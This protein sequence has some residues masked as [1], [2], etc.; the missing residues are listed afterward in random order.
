MSKM[1]WEKLTSI[2]ELEKIDEQ[3]VQAP[4]VIFKHS[5]KCSIS[6][7]ALDRI[8]RKWNQ[9]NHPAIRAY[10][11]DLISYKEVSN[12]IAAKYGVVHQSP[13]ILMIESGKCVYNDSHFGISYDVLLDKMEQ[14]T[15]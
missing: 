1:N 15:A 9:D 6:S 8:E 14:L 7:T 11:L 10:Y 3:S 4:V 12:A 13:Q 5:I 2:N